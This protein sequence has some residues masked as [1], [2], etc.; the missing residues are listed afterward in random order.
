MGDYNS[1]ANNGIMLVTGG[2]GGGGTGIYWHTF[3]SGA[4]TGIENHSGYLFPSASSFHLKV[5]VIGNT[6]SAYVNGYATPATTYISSLYSSGSVALLNN[7][8]PQSF[9][10]VV[11]SAV[12][13]PAAF[14]LLL[15]GLGGLIGLRRNQA[16]VTLKVRASNA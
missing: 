1:G 8:G 12:P 14:W 11:V 9:D 7:G 6:Y 5:D 13:I 4:H 16:H 15:S 2:M 3:Q 10:N